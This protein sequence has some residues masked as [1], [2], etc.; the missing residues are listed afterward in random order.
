L[1]NTFKAVIK[2]TPEFHAGRHTTLSVEENLAVD[3]A[4]PIIVMVKTKGRKGK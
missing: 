1:P 2:P 4:C 3:E